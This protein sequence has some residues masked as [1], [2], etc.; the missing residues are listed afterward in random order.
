MKKRKKSDPAGRDHR[1]LLSVSAVMVAAALFAVGLAVGR[2]H[3]QEPRS[4]VESTPPAETAAPK[5]A[6]LADLLP[7]LEA[8]VAANP[9]DVGQRLL[10]AQTFNE[11]GQR[12]KGIRELRIIHRA[13]PKNTE[14]T[15]LLGAA[16]MESDSRTDLN[17]A[18][19]L[20]DEAVRLNPAVSPMAR[21]YQG[22]IRVKLGDTQGAVRIW[23]DYLNHMSAGDQRRTMFQDRI[24]A[25]TGH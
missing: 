9:K 7:G 12:D 21:L 16:L 18:L 19:S 13:E 22:D 11:L 8:K 25:A 17:D 5:V 15:I 1:L 2:Y 4:E 14:V 24:A 20:L 23:Q 3:P 10:L 6:S